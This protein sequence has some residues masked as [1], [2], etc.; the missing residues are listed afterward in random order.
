M[1]GHDRDLQDAAIHDVTVYR[2]REDLCE[3]WAIYFRSLYTGTDAP[4]FDDDF[5]E[6]VSS[7][8]SDT[9]GN[10]TM[11]QDV[12]VEPSFVVTSFNIT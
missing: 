10:I 7:V 1:F 6:Y 5:K 4:D 12:T 8:V 9:F 2:S 3:Q 11:N